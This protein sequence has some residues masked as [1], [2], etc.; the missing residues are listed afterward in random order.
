V[1]KRAAEPPQDRVRFDRWLWAA[2]FFK[3]RTLATQAIAGGKARLGGRRVKPGAMVAA[4]DTIQVRKGP[5]ELELVVR[6]VAEKRGP[7]KE[8]A[9]LY[10][11]TE[12]G[13]ASREAMALALKSQPV[14]VFE[15]KG[16]P[17][18]RDRRRIEQLV[19][20]WPD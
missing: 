8:A 3:S 18:K 14:V 19:E 1:T 2:R 10:E 5:Y 11:E 6:A 9:R 4:G 7:A 15:G 13:R 20:E 12:A 16:R 17:T